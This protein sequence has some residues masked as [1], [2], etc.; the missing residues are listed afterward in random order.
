MANR[1]IIEIDF[2]RKCTACD[3]TGT[4]KNGLCLSCMSA[5]IRRGDYSSIIKQGRSPVP[6]GPEPMP[7]GPLT[8]P[9]AQP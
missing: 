7:T 4:L 6:S 1:I 5:G 2:D 9:E 8:P 3:K